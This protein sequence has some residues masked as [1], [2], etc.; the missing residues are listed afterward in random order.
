[1]HHHNMH[2]MNSQINSGLISN[3]LPTRRRGTDSIYA[4][5]DLG[6]AGDVIDRFRTGDTLMDGDRGIY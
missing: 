3:A 4:P 2:L 6:A 1:M 5:D